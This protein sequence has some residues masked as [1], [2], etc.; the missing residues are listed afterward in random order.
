M[1]QCVVMG[2]GAVGLMEFTGMA[3]S[4]R[5]LTLGKPAAAQQSAADE[6]G[7]EVDSAQ[8]GLYFVIVDLKSFKDTVVILRELN[9]CFPHAANDTQV[10]CMYAV[11]DCCICWRFVLLIQPT[12]NSLLKSIMVD[13]V[14]LSC[15]FR[16]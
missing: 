9:A 13:F 5:K 16:V 8:G 10:R 6:G 2:P 1:D 14:V 7:S 11:T 15:N 12:S 4:L 3:C